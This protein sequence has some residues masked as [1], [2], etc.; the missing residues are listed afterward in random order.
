MTEIFNAPD[1]VKFSIEKKNRV[2][3]RN[4]SGGTE[5]KEKDTEI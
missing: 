4:G 5:T 2:I 1:P 3:D